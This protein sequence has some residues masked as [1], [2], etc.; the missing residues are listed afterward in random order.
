MATCSKCKNSFE[1]ANTDPQA[2]E[3]SAC[4]NCWDEWKKYGIMV[5]NEMRLDM[6]MREHRQM[7]KKYEKAFFSGET[8]EGGMKDYT[9]EEERVPDKPPH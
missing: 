4:Q 1:E 5:I 7:L 8:P 3:Y 9:K 6:S 2:K